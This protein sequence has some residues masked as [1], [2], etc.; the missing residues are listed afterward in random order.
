LALIRKLLGLE[1]QIELAIE[2]LSPHNLTHYAVDL[3]KTFSAF[4]RDCYVVDPDAPELS[5][6]RLL[7]S[8]AT[9]I[10]LAKTLAL[11]GISA[12]ERM[13]LDEENQN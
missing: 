7:L 11:L 6:A 3:T 1:E 9:R 10:V 2:R 8:Q 5:E 12:P 4:Y 13:W